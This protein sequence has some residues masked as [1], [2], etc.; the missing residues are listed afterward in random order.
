MEYLMVY[1]LGI[2]F[3]SIKFNTYFVIVKEPISRGQNHTSKSA[4]INFR[5]W[6]SLFFFLTTRVFLAVVPKKIKLIFFSDLGGQ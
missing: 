5:N 1:D 2:D 6:D 3:R 4:P